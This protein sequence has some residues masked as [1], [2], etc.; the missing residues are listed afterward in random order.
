MTVR[1]ALGASRMRLGCQLFVES[2]LLAAAGA[3]AGLALA[4]LGA[5][6]LVGSSDRNRRGGAGSLD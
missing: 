1:L 4:R 2:L 3:A 6:L 5:A